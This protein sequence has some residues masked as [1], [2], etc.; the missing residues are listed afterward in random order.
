ML[1]TNNNNNY[2]AYM[3]W[4]RSS[5]GQRSNSPPDLASA[6]FKN[7]EFTDGHGFHGDYQKGDPV[8]C[9]ASFTRTSAHG[10]G[11]TK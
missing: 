5:M 8:H 1:K 2:S 11:A 4:Y 6:S 7:D 3:S 10:W 9:Y